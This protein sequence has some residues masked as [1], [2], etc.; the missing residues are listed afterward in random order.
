MPQC[1]L[2]FDLVVKVP[3]SL[4][5]QELYFGLSLMIYHGWRFVEW[6]WRPVQQIWRSNSDFCLQY[7]AEA[8]A[9]AKG[10]KG[11]CG[12][13]PGLGHWSLDRMAVGARGASE[14]L[15]A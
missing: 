14:N 15:K 8:E 4:V 2:S 7:Q 12:N 13:L 3:F 6:I 11:G 9:E 10:L 5:A 1:Q